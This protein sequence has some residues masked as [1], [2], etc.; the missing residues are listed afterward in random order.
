MVQ[1]PAG[2]KRDGEE[3]QGGDDSDAQPETWHSELQLRVPSLG[4]IRVGMWLRETEVRLE[5]KAH[6]DATLAIL[7]QGVARLDERLRAAGLTSV[8]IDARL[9]HEEGAD[10]GTGA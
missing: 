10:G 3:G 8:L 9:L 4:D 5:L 6:D 2:A 1:L 7:Q